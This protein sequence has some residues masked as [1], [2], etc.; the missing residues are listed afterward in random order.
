MLLQEHQLQQSETTPVVSDSIED[1]RL[2]LADQQRQNI[3]YDDAA[4]ISD[5]L[6]E[7]YEI[8]AEEVADEPTL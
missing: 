8:L 3:S 1:L 5:A 2:I 6:I 4:Q 7:F